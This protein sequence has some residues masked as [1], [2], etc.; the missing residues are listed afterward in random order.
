[1]Q[2]SVLHYHFRPGGVRRVIELGLPALM[3][4]AGGVTRVVLASGEAPD[5]AWRQFMEEQLFPAE[6]EWL[7][8][9]A[10]GY[11]SEQRVPAEDVRHSIREVLP[12]LL[13]PGGILW[14]HNL[15]VGRNMILA[16]KVAAVSSNAALW[17][18]HHDWWWDGRWERWPEMRAQ[19]IDSLEEAVAATVPSGERVRHFCVNAFDARRLRKWTGLAAGFLP[20]PMAMDL[21][22]AEEQEQAR[23]F[24]RGIT[25]TAAAWVY[26]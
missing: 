23:D 24:L 12:R 22:A 11:W 13:T 19:R 2:F 8:E 6:V 14:A 25:G 5:A 20:N 18:H 10:L 17:L 9:P 15:C 16:R 26:P 21:V 1:M 7:T 4:A 3:H